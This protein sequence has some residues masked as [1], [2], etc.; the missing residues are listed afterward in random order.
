MTS[1]SI[2]RRWLLLRPWI[3]DIAAGVLMV[4]FM[5]SAILLAVGLSK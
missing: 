3:S 5:G 4:A 2:R 1:P